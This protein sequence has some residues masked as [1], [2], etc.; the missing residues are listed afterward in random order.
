LLQ[1]VKWEAGMFMPP[2][3]DNANP[4]GSKHLMA[5]RDLS[6][7]VYLN[8]A[9]EGGELYFTAL[10]I[11]I[12][13]RRGMFVAVTAGFHHGHAVLRVDSGTRLTMP[14]FLTFDSEK[15]DR[16]LLQRLHT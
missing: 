12:K 15:V 4:D 8:D 13:P 9:Y 11:A 5:Y 6:G 2:H 3:A 1:I 10:D 7:I 14:F 16:T